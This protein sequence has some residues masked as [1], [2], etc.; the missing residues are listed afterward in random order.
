MYICQLSCTIC[1]VCDACRFVG[2]ALYVFNPRIPMSYKI[3]KTQCNIV[4]L[5]IA[6]QSTTKI[7]PLRGCFICNNTTTY[8][9]K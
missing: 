8:K 4:Q 1:D 5:A 6:A 9:Y 2:H 7:L 3:W